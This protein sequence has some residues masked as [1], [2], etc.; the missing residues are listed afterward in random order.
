MVFVLVMPFCLLPILSRRHLDS[1]CEGRLGLDICAAFDH[2]NHKA[3][4]FK[5]Q[6]LGVGGPIFNILTK[7]F[8]K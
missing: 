7:V 6:Q 5:L 3:R 1:G 8:I 4:L 2:V